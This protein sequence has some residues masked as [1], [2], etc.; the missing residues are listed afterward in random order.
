MNVKQNWKRFL[1]VG[2][3]HGQLADPKA[4]RAVLEFKKRWRPEFT[5][6]LGDAIDCTAFRS[7]AKGQHDETEPVSPDLAAGLAFLDALRPQVYLFGNHEDRLT[8][9]SKHF[10]AIVSGYA[11]ALLD[12]ISDQCK[13]SK[14]LIIPYGYR[15]EYQLGNYKLMHG[16][17]YSEHAARDNAEIHGNCIV[18]HCHRAMMSTGR[19]SDCPTGVSVGCLMDPAQAGYAK[20]RKSTY[21]WSQG[22]AWGEYSDKQTVVWLH[23]QPQGQAEWRLPV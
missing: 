1:V 6:H 15:Q 4:L 17:I 12:A 7:G 18:A 20:L 11:S 21:A 10:N 8:T 5:A 2:C 16:A 22:F 23:I 19:R 14:T 13:K 3:S 9:L